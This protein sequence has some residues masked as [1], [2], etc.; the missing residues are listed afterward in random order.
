MNYT[1]I[2]ISIL[3]AVRSG[4]GAAKLAKRIGAIPFV[5]DFTPADKLI[6]QIAILNSEGIEYECGGHS[7]KVFD[8]EFIVTSP[9]VPSTAPVLVK[10]KELNIP[11]ISELEFSSRFCKGKIIAITG[12][13][14][15]TTTTSLMSHLLNE[16]ELKCFT[17]GNI[18][19]AFSEIA[20]IVKDE[21]FVALEV[22]SF[23]L[24]HIVEF[25]PDFSI[26]LN[27]TPDHLDRYEN[28]FEN[29]KN[30]K[31]LISKNQ[32][33]TDLFIYNKDDKETPSSV[34]ETKANV[35]AFSLRG[36]VVNGCYLRNE[37]FIYCENSEEEIICTIKDSSL[38]GEHNY[39][40]TLAVLT[41]AKKLNVS[42]SVIK[43][44]LKSFPG[45]E[46]R[47]EFVREL[48]GVKYINDS[49]ATNVDAVWYALRSFD[50]PINLIL[51]GKDKGNDYNQII[52]PVK[53]NVKKIYAV[54]SS[55]EKVKEFFSEFVEVEIMSSFEHCVIKAREEAKI[56][57]IVLLSPAC[58]SFDMFNSYEHRG[59]IFKKLVN[60]L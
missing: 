15:K 14:G 37:D 45:V 3:G 52:E 28:K 1:G 50:S 49:K 10:A 13:N 26:I 21:E 5:S 22:S 19:Y 16:A 55:A 7:D 12:T 17:A 58:A 31:S 9:G 57:E 59:E 18:G 40:N 54:G 39:A 44:A 48:D 24:D 38:C 2:K 51:G 36:K 53:S 27:I 6:E 43:N 29:Y 46:H 20:D 41:V 47:L 35:Y 42:N 23:Q 34:T 60:E 32:T 8:A 30:S 25:K 33:E 56:N 11:V 4:I